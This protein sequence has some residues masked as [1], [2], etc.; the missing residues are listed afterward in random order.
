MESIPRLLYFRS[1]ASVKS[2]VKHGR[3]MEAID[4]LSN[5]TTDPN[6]RNALLTIRGTLRNVQNQEI[7]GAISVSD[8]LRERAKV[9]DSV[10]RIS[11]EIFVGT[12]FKWLYFVG[13]L[14]L[15]AAFWRTQCN[16]QPQQNK[17]LVSSPSKISEPVNDTV[18]DQLNNSSSDKRKAQRAKSSVANT[19]LK[20]IDASE[21]KQSHRNDAEY[22][23][24]APAKTISEP[25]LI[26][27][28]VINAK[29]GG[30][31]GVVVRSLM[32]DSVLTKLNGDF[33]LKIQ[34]PEAIPGS[35]I[36]LEFEKD[37]QGLGSESIPKNQGHLL[38]QVNQ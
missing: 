35:Y 15:T 33:S 21:I 22:S 11:D 8:A 18:R 20:N 14:V 9:T 34:S 1:S 16:Q 38:Y 3:L 23:N 12:S 7:I 30:I 24:S 5:A 32:G 37:R 36:T 25:L 4:M 6:L 10:L 19:P 26:Q 13:I 17:I 27:G 31:A 28:K 2:L 29:G